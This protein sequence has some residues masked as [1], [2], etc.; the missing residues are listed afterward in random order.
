MK[1]RPRK[2][3]RR[4]TYRGAL[5]KSSPEG[6]QSLR[7]WRHHLRHRSPSS[8]TVGG[9]VGLSVGTQPSPLRKFT[10]DGDEPA[11]GARSALGWPQAST[12]APLPVAG[13]LRSAG[14]DARPPL[15]GASPPFFL[16]LRRCLVPV[17]VLSPYILARLAGRALDVTCLAAL[18]RRNEQLA[19]PG[20]GGPRGAGGGLPGSG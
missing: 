18:L 4:R 2:S 8:T 14:K 7:A 20:E 15:S 10:K 12:A 11:R 16:L 5:P 1:K 6:G 17:A 3:G 9:S 13:R 19:G